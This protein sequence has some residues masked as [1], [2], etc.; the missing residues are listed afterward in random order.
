[1][2]KMPRIGTQLI[3][4]KSLR[5][6]CT[7]LA[8]LFL[9]VGCTSKNRPLSSSEHAGLLIAE[10]GE[11]QLAPC[12]AAISRLTKLA[13]EKE[14]PGASSRVL[15]LNTASPLALSPS[16]GLLVLSK[17]MLL[18][19]PTE[20]EAFFI[21]AHEVGHAELGHHNESQNTSLTRPVA[22]KREL[23][24]SADTYALKRLLSSGYL[25]RAAI[26]ALQRVDGESILESG[27]YGAT[28]AYPS[29]HERVQSLVQQSGA[30]LGSQDGASAVAL[31]H[32]D[33]QECRE[34]LR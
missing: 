26:S 7:V 31:E 32:R 5:L 9:L 23:E 16:P 11:L 20:A 12:A 33:Y 27:H 18:L 14:N 30:L 17:G 34:A 6:A 3:H 8:A 1:V 15:L 13:L 4:S 24:L 21:I 28:A 22:N 2:S 25:L 10:Y 29:V 19:L